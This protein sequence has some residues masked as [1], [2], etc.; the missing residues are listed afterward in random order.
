MAK[1][2]AAHR[3]SPPSRGHARIAA[4]TSSVRARGGRRGPGGVGATTSSLRS[5]SIE[6]L[7]RRGNTRFWQ[8]DF[9][10]AEQAYA[11]LLA[12]LEHAGRPDDAGDERLQAEME[13]R[14][15]TALRRAGALKEA[16][17]AA[18][19]ALA[20]APGSRVVHAAGHALLGELH[21]LLGNRPLASIAADKAVELCDGLEE[22]VRAWALCAR[23]RNLWAAKSFDEAR[24]AFALAG[25]YAVRGGDEPNAVQIAGNEGMCLLELGLLPQARAAVHAAAERAARL[26]HPSTEATWIVGLARIALA[27]GETEEAAR[28]AERALEIARPLGLELTVFRAQWLLQYLFTLAHPGETD[29]V[30]LAALRRMR[31]AL[32]DY[33]GDREVLDLREALSS[34]KPPESPVASFTEGCDPVP[35]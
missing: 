14:R 25:E 32:A 5:L 23:G 31:P 12:R 19:H 15:A 13:I 33:D 28:L 4:V 2:S 3:A 29:R 22:R 34:G 9:A 20:V 35:R 16:R 21:L 17:A 10:G 11:A 1:K 7:D 24:Q 18:E 26:G 27:E 8:G 6:E 30:R